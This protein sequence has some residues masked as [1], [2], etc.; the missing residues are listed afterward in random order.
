MP[1]QR[2]G[3]DNQTPAHS[4]QKESRPGSAE[5]GATGSGGAAE[6]KAQVRWGWCA[7]QACVGTV[8]VIIPQPNPPASEQ[9]NQ[10]P[11]QGRYKRIL[12]V[13]PSTVTTRISV[14]PYV[15]GP[16]LLGK[17]YAC[18][19]KC[20]WRNHGAATRRQCRGQRSN[21]AQH[22]PAVWWVG[23]GRGMYAA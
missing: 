8:P 4:A 3:S 19:G 9:A 16:H 5:N 13:R 7:R 6:Q 10:R 22:R 18:Y 14:Q 2:C 1:E 17:R 15:K 11:L 23:S 21:H 20:A 12:Y